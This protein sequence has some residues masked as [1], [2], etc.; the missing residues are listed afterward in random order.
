MP[1]IF[2][3]K[4]SDSLRTI[5]PTINGTGSKECLLDGGSQIVSMDKEVAMSLRITW[6]ADIHIFMQS[7]N[8]TI[9]KT[10]GM[11]EN[12]P[13]LFNHITLY[14]QFHIIKNPAYDILLGR[15]FDTLTK[16]NIQKYNRWWT[17]NNNN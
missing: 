12:V 4:E 16:S 9:E 10:K 11:S 17:D 6:D 13:F 14:M 5:H 8:K 1:D 3:A 7:A 2:V 15:P